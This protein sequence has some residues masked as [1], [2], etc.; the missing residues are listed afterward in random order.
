M[1][2]DNSYER[3]KLYEEVCSEPV[4][5]VAKRYGVS[6]VAIHKACK[7]LQVPVPPRGYWARLSAGQSVTRELLPPYYGPHTVRRLSLAADRPRPATPAKPKEQLVFL[8]E[9]E[10]AKVLEFCDELQVKD[11]LTNPHPLI[12]QDQEV[13][14]E[15]KRKE[16]ERKPLGY[17]ASES[18]SDHD[19]W[20]TWYKKIL[21]IHAQPEDMPRAYRLLN[22]IFH[23][24]ES[25]GGSVRLDGK[26]GHTQ[27]VWLG[28]P[29]RIRLRSK[30]HDFTLMIEDYHAPRK[31]WRDTKRKQLESEAGSFVIG[32]LECAHALRTL[33]EERRREEQL[34]WQ[35]ERERLERA[36]RQK[37][38]MERFQSLEE[39]A[40]DWQKARVIEQYVAELQT[41]AD[42]ET[43]DRKRRRL[44]D[45]I[46]WAKEKIAW[47]DPLIAREDPI[48]GKRYDDGDED[49][50]AED[51]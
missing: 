49:D 2:S 32:L 14:A 34:R 31:N 30:E 42:S 10:R 21:D 6:D 16:K 25:L 36:Q 23:A 18:S 46:A 41:Q 24:V 17:W 11:R 33:R 48:L 43:D 4:T 35:R 38:E 29:M 44:L 12:R 5:A 22:A 45:Y 47:L 28:E 37:E 1:I 39:N 9:Q 3:D 27:V 8:E 51:W 20:S 15:H 26:E 7:R 13:R 19:F 40:L 50:E